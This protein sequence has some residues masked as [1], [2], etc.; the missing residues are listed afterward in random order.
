EHEAEIILDE[1]QDNGDG[2]FNYRFETTNGIAEERVGVPGSQGQSNMKG[3]YSFNLPDGSRFQ[4]SF[5]ADENGYN[6][7]SPFI[8]TDHPL[9]A[10]VIELLA[11]VEELKRQG[12]TWDDKGVR[13]T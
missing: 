11:L 5:A 6:A 1:R 13:I 8:P 2:N 3:G 12:A 9:P 4:L 7:D 10:H